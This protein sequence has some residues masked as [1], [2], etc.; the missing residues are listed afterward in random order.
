MSTCAY[1]EAMEKIQQLTRQ[2]KLK[3]IEEVAASLQQEVEER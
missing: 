2:E 1:Q 3:L